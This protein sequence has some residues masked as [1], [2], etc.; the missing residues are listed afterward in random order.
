MELRVCEGA[1]RASMRAGQ[2]K[3][4]GAP[5]AAASVRSRAT[6]WQRRRLLV[7]AGMVVSIYFPQP[8]ASNVEM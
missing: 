8:V 7:L 1:V 4:A 2:L 3:S 5:V 6:G